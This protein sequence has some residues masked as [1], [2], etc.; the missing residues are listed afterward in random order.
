M[1]KVEIEKKAYV[2]LDEF[3]PDQ[4]LSS[5]TEGFPIAKFLDD[6]IRYVGRVAPIRALGKGEDFSENTLVG[7]NNN[8]IELPEGFVRLIA[9]Q[10][11]DWSLPVIEA[12][13]SDDPKYMQQADPI[14]KG[15]TKRP[16][17]FICDGGTTLEWYSS[18]SEEINKARAFVVGDSDTEFPDK[19][20]EVIAW[21]TAELVLSALNNV[22][23]VQFAQTQLKQLF[24]S[25]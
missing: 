14:L 8:G 18:S 16:L 15:S 13:Y 25:L 6:A 23:A 5:N 2:C 4:P 3:Y 12:L 9:F 11:S 7:D 24:D 20:G 17:V 22:T 19:I 21:K 10:M 1:K